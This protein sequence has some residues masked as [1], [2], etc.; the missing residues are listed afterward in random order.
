M[1]GKIYLP[2]TGI[3]PNSKERCLYYSKNFKCHYE[4]KGATYEVDPVQLIRSKKAI[5]VIYHNDHYTAIID[6]ETPMHMIQW[7]K[8]HFYDIFK[9]TKQKK[10]CP[11]CNKY[12]GNNKVVQYDLCKNWVHSISS[13]R[14]YI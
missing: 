5:M 13:Y 1:L 11:V 4:I 14:F 12:W 2:D 10:L 9:N 8:L 6:P 3:T 7:P